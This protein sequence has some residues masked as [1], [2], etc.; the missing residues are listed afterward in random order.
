MP[1]SS[2]APRK[3]ATLSSVFMPVSMSVQRS[4]ARTRYTFTMLGRMGSCSYT[5]TT[6]SRIARAFAASGMLLVKALLNGERDPQLDTPRGHRAVLDEC[7]HARDLRL[8]DAVDRRRS[9]R[10]R[11]SDGVLD[12]VGGRARQMNRLLDHGVC[13][14]LPDRTSCRKRVRRSEER[15][16]GKECGVRW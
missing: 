6:P 9:T 15:R 16:V 5:R 1:I 8:P 10:H 2:R 3:A 13:T 11:K 4:P 14:S 7:R 12:R